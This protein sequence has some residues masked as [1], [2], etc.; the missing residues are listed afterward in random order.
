M[1][2]CLKNMSNDLSTL[3]ALDIAH[4]HRFTGA[5]RELEE[6]IFDL[7]LKNGERYLMSIAESDS[8]DARRIAAHSLK[9]SA[10]GIGALQ[11]EY[12]A[13]MLEDLASAASVERTGP[14]SELQQAFNRV[15]E[16]LAAYL[17]GGDVG[18]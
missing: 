6:E 12:A 5:D 1:G 15:R 7:F 18:S 16:A 8:A 14:L 3:S 10:R 4:L 9:G 17:L 13:Q 11:V 2:F